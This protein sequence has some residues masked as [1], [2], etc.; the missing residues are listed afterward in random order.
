MN[1]FNKQ[2]I[3]TLWCEYQF[4]I[5]EHFDSEETLISYLDQN[6][7]DNPTMFSEVGCSNWRELHDDGLLSWEESVI[8]TRQ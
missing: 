6:D 5:D 7:I 2:K 3:V 4:P 8:I 1:K